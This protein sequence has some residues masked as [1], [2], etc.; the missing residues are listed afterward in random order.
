MSVIFPF[1]TRQNL[2]SL[3]FELDAL[4]HRRT[5]L[6]PVKLEYLNKHHL[7]R[8]RSTESGL[9]AQALRGQGYIRDAFPDTSVPIFF[10]WAFPSW[11]TLPCSNASTPVEYIEKV[12]LAL[13]GRLVTL[14][15]L[16]TAAPYFFIPPAWDDA[17]ARAM[18]DGISLADY[19]AAV[20]G[21]VECLVKSTS[22]WD[23]QTIADSLH[24]QNSVAGIKPARFMIGLRHATSGVKVRFLPCVLVFSL[25]Q[26]KSPDTEW[27]ECRRNNVCLG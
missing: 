18:L 19:Q 2:T 17:E 1:E 5:T 16:P 7:V 9:R 14:M 12:I 3:Q 27:S 25:E 24:A 8:S 22:Q 13:Q 11:L 23:V 21:T 26:S 20:R 6:D 15:D 10:T 4:T